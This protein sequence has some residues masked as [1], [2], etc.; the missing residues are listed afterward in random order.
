M[1]LSLKTAK[2]IL[3]FEELVLVHL[4]IL[5]ELVCS[6]VGYCSCYSLLLISDELYYCSGWKIE[7]TNEVAWNV[8]LA[9]APLFSPTHSSTISLESVSLQP[10]TNTFIS[11]TP[12]K[13]EFLKYR[14]YFSNKQYCQDDIDFTDTVACEKRCL[15]R[16]L[17]VEI[18][19][20][21]EF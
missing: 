18:L 14:G 21:A 7:L 16:N 8:F 3:K 2:N 6:V 10:N 4:I 15:L 20:G 17:K 19:Q 1:T 12:E 13:Y 5:T 11:F 9:V